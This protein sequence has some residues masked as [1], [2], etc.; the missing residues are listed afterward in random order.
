MDCTTSIVMHRPRNLLWPLCRIKPTFWPL[1]G[2]AYLSRSTTPS[3]RTTPLLFISAPRLFNPLCSGTVQTT[4]PKSLFSTP[5][6]AVVQ[7]NLWTRIL[8]PPLPFFGPLDLTAVESFKKVDIVIFIGYEEQWPHLLV[9]TVTTNEEYQRQ[10][11]LMIKWS[12]RSRGLAP[13]STQP[14]R[15]KARQASPLPYHAMEEPSSSPLNR[16]KA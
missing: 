16:L 1:P 6:K 3:D 2:C 7:I 8:A 13:P 12:L 9:E 14:T 11:S 10:A 15:V 5:A 4:M